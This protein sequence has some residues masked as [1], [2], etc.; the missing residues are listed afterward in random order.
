MPEPIPLDTDISELGAAVDTDSDPLWMASDED[1]D[2][3]APMRTPPELS[4]AEI[5]PE[6]VRFAAP[7]TVE[8]PSVAQEHQGAVLNL[9][10]SGLACALPVVLHDGERIRCRFRLGLGETPIATDAEVVWRR[11]HVGD[12]SLYGLRFVDLPASGRERV[13]DA[14][15]ER[16]E[17]RAGEWPLP[18]LPALP[19]GAPRRLNAWIAGL[20]GMA[21]GALLSVGVS[22]L[23]AAVRGVGA[24]DASGP[25]ERE[26]TVVVVAPGLAPVSTNSTHMV[27][28]AVAAEVEGEPSSDT[29]LETGI[30]TGV[31]EASPVS[32]GSAAAGS[33]ASSEPADSAAADRIVAADGAVGPPVLRDTAHGVEIV[34][35]TDGPVSSYRT[36]WLEAPRRLVID[37]PGVESLH[38]GLAFPMQ[39]ALVSLLRIGKYADKVR[40]VVETSDR[41]ARKIEAR[42]EGS[43]L[44]VLLRR[45]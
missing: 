8:L 15:R 11:P 12:D 33:P 31:I 23:P 28:P 44:V 41:V 43:D 7:V 16:A 37:I 22:F 42:P 29:G 34:L 2:T 36:F 40:F 32:S 26:H 25:S 30:E 21:I 19:G 4:E 14:V 17:G 5:P 45:E 3:R 20:A 18:V 38:R 35:R 9:S 10:A 13:R 24:T 27:P 1:E 39:H 6:R